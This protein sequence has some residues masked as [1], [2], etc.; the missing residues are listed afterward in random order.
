[1]GMDFRAPRPK[2]VTE[3]GSGE[4]P[5]VIRYTHSSMSF[6]AVKRAVI[7]VNKG[8]TTGI[9]SFSNE[10]ECEMPFFRS[11]KLKNVTSLN[12]RSTFK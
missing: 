6:D 12:K 1:M 9:S 5:I 10:E 7:A 8:G 11:K 2:R 3:V 4:C